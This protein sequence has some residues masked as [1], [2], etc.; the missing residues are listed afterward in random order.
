MNAT[1]TKHSFIKI[2]ILFLLSYS[3]PVVALSEIRSVYGYIEPITL[4][5]W[6]QPLNARLDTGAESSSISAKDINI[7]KIDTG[8]NYVAFRVAHP[9][10]SNEYY[11][12]LP[13]KKEIPIKNR[14]GEDNDGAES[15]RP[16]VEIPLCFDKKQY[17]VEANLIDRSE[18]INPVLIGRDTLDKF[19]ADIDP[20]SKN[21]I[22]GC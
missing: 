2:F 22:Q 20:S 19:R 9:S 11:Y 13:L 1:N 8:E 16:V 15:F 3:L 17:I 12:D 7:Y 18:L 10:I 4:L 14:Q 6:K 5:P 21:T